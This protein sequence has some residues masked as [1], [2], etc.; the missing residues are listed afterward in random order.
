MK[1]L[2]G[3]DIIEIYRIREDIENIGNTFLKRVFTQTEID[4][5][6]KKKNQKFESYAARFAAKEAVYKAIAAKVDNLSWKDIEIVN[7]KTGKPNVNI[8]KDVE[9]L[10]YIEI[11]L[12]HSKEYAVAYAIAVF[13]EN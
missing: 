12:S 4:Y 9:G 2:N 1:I 7:D 6:E 3:T 5:C 11:S 13:K 8:K 10:D